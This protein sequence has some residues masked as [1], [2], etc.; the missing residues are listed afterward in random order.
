MRGSTLLGRLLRE[1]QGIILPVPHC[2]WSSISF[3]R[4]VSASVK[5]TPFVLRPAC[6]R[7]EATGSSLRLPGALPLT[8]ESDNSQ[9]AQAPIVLS[10]HSSISVLSRSSPLLLL[11]LV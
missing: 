6:Y 7:R 5:T 11:Y 4:I 3:A 1:V 8:A 10:E 2:I 9:P